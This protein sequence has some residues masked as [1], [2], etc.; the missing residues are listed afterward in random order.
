MSEIEQHAP[1][2]LTPIAQPADEQVFVY[3]A[4]FN[5]S[6]LDRAQ[7]ELSGVERD[8][9]RV[10]LQSTG[11]DIHCAFRLANL[12]RQHCERLEVIVPTYAKSAATF[13]C[14]SA[15][16][17]SLGPLGELG[18][19]D[20]Q[21]QDPRHDAHRISA[22]DS[23]EALD[24]LRANALETFDYTVRMLIQLSDLSQREMVQH[25]RE[26]TTSLMEPLYRQVRP[27]DITEHARALDIAKRYGE[28]LMSR[29]AYSELL[30][31]HASDILHNSFLSIRHTNSSLT[32]TKRRR[33][34]CA[35]YSWMSRWLFATEIC[36]GRAPSASSRLM[37]G[38]TGRRHRTMTG[39]QKEKL[40]DMR[41]R[42][43]SA[44]QAALS[45]RLVEDLKDERRTAP[46][47]KWTARA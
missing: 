36:C 32:I 27:L 21:T 28:I 24:H 39:Q 41:R 17:I 15:D 45:R 13:F 3:C 7:Q 23:Y 20:V 35:S 4:G 22:L 5:G 2:P 1:R 30:P 8:N 12:M 11:G 33:W 29:Y 34:G 47:K 19:L 10:V 40:T 42:E 16:R 37:M 38:A 31:E 18:P 46:D 6:A 9:I 26:F 25:A 14:L 44:K 43:E